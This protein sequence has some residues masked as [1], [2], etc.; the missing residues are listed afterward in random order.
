MPPGAEKEVWAVS[1]RN[2][3]PEA[4]GGQGIRQEGA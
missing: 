2:Y 1:L 3:T 4:T